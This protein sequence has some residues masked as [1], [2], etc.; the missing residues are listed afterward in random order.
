[1][2]LLLRETGYL[3]D[4]LGADKTLRIHASLGPLATPDYAGDAA[5]EQALLGDRELFHQERKLRDLCVKLVKQHGVR[6]RFIGY[7]NDAA[8]AQAKGY[9]RSAWEDRLFALRSTAAELGES[10]EF[11]PGYRASDTWGVADIAW[12]DSRKADPAESR[13]YDRAHLETG[14][15][16]IF[17]ANKLFDM[18][19]NGLLR[20]AG[21]PEAA[22]VILFGS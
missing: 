1:V 3:L 18:E 21:G 13:S 12:I 5:R 10:L 2:R 9:S 14:G 20:N 19:F 22:K 7:P 8:F 16:A 15:A 4:Y 17:R 11:A 6:I